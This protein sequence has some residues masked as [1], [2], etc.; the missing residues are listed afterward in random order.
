MYEITL[1]ENVST[2]KVDQ[3]TIPY[4]QNCFEFSVTRSLKRSLN[5]IVGAIR[6][7]TNFRQRNFSL[8]K[9]SPLVVIVIFVIFLALFTKVTKFL[10]IRRS[11]NRPCNNPQSFYPPRANKTDWNIELIKLQLSTWQQS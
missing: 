4:N 5:K 8:S 3:P 11:Y 7:T 6:L 2:L 1:S 9:N 10:A